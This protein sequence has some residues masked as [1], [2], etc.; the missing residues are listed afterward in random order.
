M[1]TDIEAEGDGAFRW[2]FTMDST[3]AIIPT[4][5]G[6]MDGS[7]GTTSPIPQAVDV[8]EMTGQTSREWSLLGRNGP[9]MIQ[10]LMETTTE[11]PA[12]TRG[13]V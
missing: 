10:R 13:R 12:T 4:K 9:R 3:G 1:F 6:Q 7:D 2:A 5:T 11:S 8:A